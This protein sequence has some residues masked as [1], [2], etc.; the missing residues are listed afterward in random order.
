MSAMRRLLLLPLAFALLVG[1]ADGEEARIAAAMADARTAAARAAQFEAQAAK[2]VGAAAQARARSGA[3]IADIDRIESDITAAEARI[4]ALS[5]RQAAL[6]ARLAAQRQPVAELT[7]AL[8]RIARR[9]PAFA[10]V[11]P[12]SVKDMVRVRVL[13]AGAIPPI[14]RHA[15]ALRSETALAAR[16][17]RDAE[18]ARIALAAGRARLQEQRNALARLERSSALQA[19]ASRE[20]AFLESERALGFGEQGRDLVQK[21]S[22]AARADR[23]H[24]LAQLPGPTPRPTLAPPVS[25]RTAPYRL[26]VAGRLLGGTGA[27]SDAGVHARG[28]S[29][30]VMRGSPVSAPRAGRIVY[31]GRFRSYGEVLILD[32]GGG[33]TSTITGL[34]V[35][36]VRQGDSVRAGDPL[37]RSGDRID[38]E[39]RRGGSPRAIAPFLLPA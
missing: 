33:W 13:L 1:A 16:L 32:H 15:S 27:L 7:A 29:F 9:P 34:A 8:E 26:P 17:R 10:L 14:E 25:P 24:A 2:A 12:G 35:L 21:Q 20:N 11:H 18:A 22:P 36:R 31:A 6:D 23:L 19:D 30:A 39:L 3:L 37:G 5:R 38:V 28:L 4:A